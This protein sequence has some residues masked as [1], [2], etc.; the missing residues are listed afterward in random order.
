MRVI[1]FIEIFD[2]I[3]IKQHDPAD[4]EELSFVWERSSG[5]V[6]ETWKGRRWGAKP[7][8]I[9][10]PQPQMNLWFPSDLVTLTSSAFGTAFK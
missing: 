7:L 2:Q 5:H 8:M 6:G 10:D 1:E 4:D 9:R 3:D